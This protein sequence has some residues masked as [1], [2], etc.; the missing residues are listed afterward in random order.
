MLSTQIAEG[1][2]HVHLSDR[3]GDW[4]QLLKIMAAMTDD[5]D[6]SNVLLGENSG[7]VLQHVA[8][9]RTL[10]ATPG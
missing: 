1:K 8:V 2:L 9:A 7:R 3:P 4:N 5:A 6:R 10:M